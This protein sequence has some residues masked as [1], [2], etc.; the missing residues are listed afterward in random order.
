MLGH[1]TAAFLNSLRLTPNPC[2]PTT[3][4]SSLNPPA[5]IVD[6]DPDTRPALPRAQLDQRA[7]GQRGFRV[8]QSPVEAGEV[9][10]RRRRRGDD[11]VARSDR[12]GLAYAAQGGYLGR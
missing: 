4:F 11:R 10:L 12:L 5:R 1:V 3:A 7:F 9:A 2:F 8:F 6:D